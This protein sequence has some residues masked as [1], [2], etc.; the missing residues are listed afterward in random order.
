MQPE[1]IKE[2]LELKKRSFLPG[3]KT[4]SRM[5]YSSW[6]ASSLSA[7]IKNQKGSWRFCSGVL[8]QATSNCFIMH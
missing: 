3:V 6:Q 7:E 8:L 1:D 5:N 2:V 4:I